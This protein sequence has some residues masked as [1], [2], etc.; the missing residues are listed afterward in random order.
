M[1]PIEVGAIGAVAVLLVR[2]FLSFLK[3]KN[4]AG[5]IAKLLSELSA[6]IEDDRRFQL[7]VVD[8]LGRIEERIGAHNRFDE[9]LRKVESK[10]ATLQSNTEH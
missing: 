7:A 2:E 9:R 1:N 5:Q 3:S 10:C 4:E 8:R 6:H